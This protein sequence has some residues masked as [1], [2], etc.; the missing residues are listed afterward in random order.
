MYIMPPY[1]AFQVPLRAF[2]ITLQKPALQVFH[3]CATEHLKSP[4]RG[5][6]KISK[7]VVFNNPQKSMFPFGVNP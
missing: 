7:L 1:H 5:F 2:S 3:T 6:Q 4:L